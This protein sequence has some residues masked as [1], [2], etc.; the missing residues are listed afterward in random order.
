M[1]FGKK[2]TLKHTIFGSTQA[3]AKF[4]TNLKKFAIFI[5]ELKCYDG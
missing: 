2:I 3:L 5:N 1:F 4:K